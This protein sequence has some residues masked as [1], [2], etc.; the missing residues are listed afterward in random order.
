MLEFL[1]QP[2]IREPFWFC[3]GIIVYRTA[4]TVITHGHMFL[5]VQ[6]VYKQILVLL[7]SV[8]NEVLFINGLKYREM[9]ENGIEESKI[10]EM[11]A[12]DESSLFKWANSMIVVMKSTCPKLYYK[13]VE[14]NNW[15][16]AMEYIQSELHKLDGGKHK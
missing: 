7:A 1:N 5:T 4:S 6:T 16:E 10:E 11:K 3:M 12:V 8:I 9:K 15:V 14:Y 2:G 13:A